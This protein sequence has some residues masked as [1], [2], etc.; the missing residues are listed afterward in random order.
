MQMCFLIYSDPKLKF[1]LRKISA[2]QKTV[3][4]VN[5]V[6]GADQQKLW[7]QSIQDQLTSVC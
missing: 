7:N 1:Q 5:E 3:A 2:G 6:E 4:A